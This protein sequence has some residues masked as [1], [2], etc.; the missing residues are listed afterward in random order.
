MR[1][2]ILGYAFI[3]SL[4][5]HLLAFMA[6]IPFPFSPPVTREKEVRIEMEVE[7]EETISPRE[8]P[9]PL[10]QKLSVAQKKPLPKP[11][12]V[13][14]REEEQSRESPLPEEKLLRAEEK[15]LFRG[16]LPPEPEKP[17]TSSAISNFEEA[18][19]MNPP[20]KIGNERR[21]LEKAE[22]EEV[23]GYTAIQTPPAEV[24]DPI[25]NI[26]AAPPSEADPLSRYTGMVRKKIEEKRRYP[27]WA[28]RNG[29][30]GKVVLNFVIRSDGYL[31]GVEVVE[32]SG[33]QLLDESAKEAIQRAT[34][35][36]PLPMK[37]KKSLKLRIPI[38]FKLEKGS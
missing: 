29:W 9:S 4:T 18:L 12:S 3:A 25:P 15:D 23:S 35:F 5:I 31:N 34:P 24:P 14:Q 21:A 2:E 28:R 10:S 37:E 16:E 38:I 17:M 7:K 22:K 8:K 33:Y 26:A 1:D 13:P 27:P 36:P 32:S 20:P 19:I 6:V 11:P 30:Q